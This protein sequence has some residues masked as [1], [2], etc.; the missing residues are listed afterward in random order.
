MVLYTPSTG[1]LA[2]V[3]ERHGLELTDDEL[4]ELRELGLGVLRACERLQSAPGHTLPTRYPRTAAWQP[5]AEENELNAWATRC[6]VAGAD[7]GVLSGKTVVVKDII[8][9]AGV[10]MSAG[11]AL[12]SG[13]VAGFDATVVTRVLD[14]GGRI[15][16]V[17]ATEDFCLSGASVSAVTGQVRNPRDPSRSAG[18][19]SSGV[20]ALVG[21]GACDVG[22]GADQ[23]GSIRIPASLSGIFGMKPTYGLVPYTGCVPID[24]SVDYLGPMARNVHDLAALLEAI[25]GY[26]D[27]L[28]PRQRSDVPIP[29][30]VDAIGEA[31]ISGLRVG[32]VR[33]GFGLHG[34]SDPVV[35]DAVRAAV[36]DL[37]VL[38]AEVAEVD[39]AHHQYA[40]D[41]HASVLLQGGSEFMV[42]GNGIGMPGKGF[43][44]AALAEASA[45]GRALQA[46]QL[47][48][49]VKFAMVIG[50]YLWDTYGGAF[51]AKA[52]N[53]A[54]AMRRA[55]DAVLSDVDLLVMPTTAVQA[56]LLPE[57]EVPGLDAVKL[58][59]DPALI[60]NTCAFNHTG[61]PALSVPVGTANDLPVGL[62]LVGRWHDE[63]TLL[64]AARALEAGGHTLPAVA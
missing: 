44:D 21:S 15:V 50:G 59:L 45:R 58:A 1:Q 53:L 43:Y 34:L 27:G 60:S 63:T 30:Y 18:G 23:G 40:M 20:A 25:A 42:R 47:F 13:H 9:M 6:D 7:S 51:Y 4:S 39:V 64:R 11:S 10:P 26:D 19:S 36:K 48:A 31:D 16:G 17:A 62:M 38:G 22:I 3:A 28:D 14:S 41:I 46:S 55:Y 12:L 61:H 5:T 33:Q 56:P 54:V 8:P 57:E 29:G 49:S 52:Q 32:L 2:A 24:V 35:D 37:E